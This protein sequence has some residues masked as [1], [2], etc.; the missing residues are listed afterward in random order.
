MMQQPQLPMHGVNQV[1]WDMP[2][3]QAIRMSSLQNNIPAYTPFNLLMINNMMYMCN[4]MPQQSEPLPLQQLIVHQYYPHIQEN[5]WVVNRLMGPQLPPMQYVQNWSVLQQRP[6][7]RS[8]YF[9]N[10]GGH[11]HV[12]DGNY[13]INRGKINYNYQRARK[14]D[15]YNPNGSHSGFGKRICRYFAKFGWC[16]NIN[17][18]F[19]HSIR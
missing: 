9:L 8:P 10:D 6:H 5:H 4:Q 15:I 14:N 19:I 7:Y 1:Y 2:P 17:C 16:K 3:E 18:S 13:K 11:D 12:R